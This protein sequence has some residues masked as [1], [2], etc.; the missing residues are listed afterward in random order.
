[1]EDDDP[2]HDI[3]EIQF[4]LLSKE[5]ILNMSVVELTE[6]KFIPKEKGTT[7]YPTYRENSV[8]DS[9]MG[10]MNP[11]D[12][13]PTCSQKSLHCPGHFGHIVLEVPVIHPLFYKKVLHYLQCFCIQCSKFLVTT[14]HLQLWGFMKY[15]RETRFN[16][17]VSQITKGHLCVHCNLTQPT[18]QFVSN[19]NEYYITY[20]TKEPETKKDII[21]KLPLRTEEIKT[22]FN[23]IS[24]E[25][26]QLLGFHNE[27]AHPRNLILEVIPVIPPRARPFI[28]SDS[29]CD[30]DLTTFL[31]DIIKANITLRDKSISETKREK[32][33]QTL[34]FSIKCMM[35]N[36][37]GLAKRQNG[38][39]MKGIKERLEGKGGLVR[40]NIQGRRNNYSARTVIGPD[41]TLKVNEIAIPPEIA[42]NLS[43]PERVTDWNLERLQALVNAGGANSVIRGKKKFYGLK[44]VISGGG[45]FTIQVGDEVQRKMQDGDWTMVNRQ[46]SQME[47]W[48]RWLP[49]RL[50]RIPIW[51]NS[52]IYIT[53]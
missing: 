51:I 32:V 5:D 42:D 25:D 38:T 20:T 7:P 4:G 15:K 13:C 35:D 11:T 36:A 22:I 2:K 37:K 10:P 44:H 29:M 16:H 14:E 26:I 31:T 43:F 45:N 30:D 53:I 34:I 19:D 3:N 1:M 8:Y 39:A 6:P 52:V 27:S 17:I 46:P 40:N 9:R 12:I 49:N 18:I 33:I 48:N 47:A 21:S 23:N 50:C 28:M 41:P 24:T